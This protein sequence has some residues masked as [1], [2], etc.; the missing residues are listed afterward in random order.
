MI[1][2][3]SKNVL[4]IQVDVDEQSELAEKLGIKAMPTVIVFG[5]EGE[6][7]RVVG[8]KTAPELIAWLDGL[9][10][11]KSELDHLRAKAET[12]DIESRYDLARS[13]MQSGKPE[14]AE[15]LFL[16]LWRDMEGTEWSGVR[17]SYLLSDLAELVEQ[18]PSARA[19]LEALRKEAYQRGSLADWFHLSSTLG[20][21]EELVAWEPT[22]PLPGVLESSYFDFLVNAGHRAKAGRLLNNPAESAKDCLRV[23][24]SLLDFSDSEGDE[25]VAEYA[26]ESTRRDLLNLYAACRAA[27][28]DEDAS[29]VRRLAL[30]DD[31]EMKSAFD[32]VDASAAT[33]P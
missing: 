31:A 22:S 6:R 13:L 33:R 15:E 5:P 24:Q 23:R 21:T 32:E 1:D 11:G 20:H 7:D 29:K 19:K 8:Y 4:A 16:T 27:G 14:E 2:Y 18:S 12:G 25:R 28:R 30:E 9:R 17:Y 10:E 26:R 3:F